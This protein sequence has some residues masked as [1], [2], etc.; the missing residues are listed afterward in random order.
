MATATNWLSNFI[1][2]S[3][4]LTSMETDAGKVYTFL[5]LAGFSA[6]ALIFVLALVPETANRTIQTNIK[7]IIGELPSEKDQ[8]YRK[9]ENKE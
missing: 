6:L 5:I 7:K 9:I 8:K 4:F 3:L 1:V 2:S